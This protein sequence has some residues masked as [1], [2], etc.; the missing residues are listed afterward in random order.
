[1]TLITLVHSAE[2]ATANIQRFVEYVHARPRIEI[3]KTLSAARS[4]NLIE[5]GDSYLGTP[6]KLIGYSDLTD[7]RYEICVVL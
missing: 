5:E 7:P 1:V 6:L 3:W 2:A 4:W